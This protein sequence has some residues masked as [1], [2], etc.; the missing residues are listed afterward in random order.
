M[1]KKYEPNYES[2][3]EWWEKQGNTYDRELK[4][5]DDAQ[6][7]LA[8]VWGDAGNAARGEQITAFNST[9][10]RSGWIGGARDEFAERLVDREN[11]MYLNNINQRIVTS[12]NLEE[13]EE[14]DVDEDYFQGVIETLENTIDNKKSDFVG[15]FITEIRNADDMEELEEIKER[16]GKIGNRAI[17]RSEFEWKSKIIRGEI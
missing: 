16:A 7:Q 12:T 4:N 3:V 8:Q 15:D 14:I 5:Y 9:N 6:K 10:N 2:L 13:L 17:F 11:E 1:N